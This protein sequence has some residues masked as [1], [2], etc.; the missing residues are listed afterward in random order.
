MTV[1]TIAVGVD[2][3][4]DA[5]RAFEWAADLARALPAELVVV[6]AVGLLEHGSHDAHAWFDALD[7]PGVHLRRIL[8]D[9]P[10]AQTLQAVGN[11]VGA[12]LLVV[13][14]RGIGGAPSRLLGSTSTQVVH[15]ATVPVVVVP[16]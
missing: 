3:S 9:G 6:H 12:D 10:P 2:A 11:E 4:P 7:A 15:E 16:R 1:S 13:G 8:R 14:S 5:R